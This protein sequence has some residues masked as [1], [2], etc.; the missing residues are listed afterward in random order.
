MLF[1]LV[2]VVKFRRGVVKV[3]ILP[4]ENGGD[5]NVPRDREFVRMV[6]GFVKC[7]VGI[8]RRSFVHLQDLIACGKR[9]R[10]RVR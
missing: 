1:R 9:R 7:C 10:K 5:E 8:L 6:M 2:I 3:E 4:L